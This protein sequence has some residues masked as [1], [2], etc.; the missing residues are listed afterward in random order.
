MIETHRNVR[1]PP[2]VEPLD[3]E[4]LFKDG[5]YRQYRKRITEIRD[6]EAHDRTVSAMVGGWCLVG[7]I[8]LCAIA[9]LIG[10]LT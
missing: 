5:N 4:R 1:L 7:G 3:L 10:R 6:L 9:Y 8:V 2:D